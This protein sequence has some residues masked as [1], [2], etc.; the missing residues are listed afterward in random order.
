M[1]E[2][3]LRSDV[4]GD[5]R[6]ERDDIVLDL[7]FDLVD[8]VD[9]ET[10]ALLHRLGHGFRNQPELGHRLSRQRLDL[11]PDAKLG[12]RLPNASHVGSAVAGDH[13]RRPFP[14]MRR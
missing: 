12:L 8:A 10:P 14:A 5:A 7:G 4:L 1:Q 13:A 6:Q 11:E 9:V 2:A 3:R